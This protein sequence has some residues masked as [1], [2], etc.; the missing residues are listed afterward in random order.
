MTPELW[1]TLV[2]GISA[3]IGPVAVALINRWRPDSPAEDDDRG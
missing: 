1:V 2:V 3:S